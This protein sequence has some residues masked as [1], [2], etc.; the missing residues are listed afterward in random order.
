M[1]KQTHPGSALL[2]AHHQSRDRHVWR[3][4]PISREEQLETELR[5]LKQ[6]YPASQGW[7]HK[8]TTKS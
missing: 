4:V 5:E 7:E 1:T 3:S 6:H 2:T 8:S